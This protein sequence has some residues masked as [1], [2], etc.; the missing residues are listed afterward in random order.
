LITSLAT[1]AGLSEREAMDIY[2]NSRLSQEINEGDYGI[3][4]LSADVLA[5]DLIANEPELFADHSE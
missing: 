4:Y 1:Q 3:Q 5:A 2:Y